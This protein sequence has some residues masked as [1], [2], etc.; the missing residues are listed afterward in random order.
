MKINRVEA[1]ALRGRS[2]KGGWSNEIRPEDSIHALIV[3]ETEDGTT[4][5]IRPPPGALLQYRSGAGSHLVQ[6]GRSASRIQASRA[7][8]TRPRL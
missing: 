4:G 8:G 2:P 1:L 3:V 5:A 7:G 6:T